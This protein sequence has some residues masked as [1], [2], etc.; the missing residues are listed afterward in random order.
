MDRDEAKHILSLCRPGNDE[1]RN[2][3][4]IAEA[5]ALL[6]T[7]AELNAWFENEQAAD[8]RIA[9]AFQTIEPPADLKASILA[10]MRA[11]A[12]QGDDES[13]K[14]VAFETPVETAKPSNRMPLWI[15]IAACFAFL[16]LSLIHI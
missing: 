14:V 3:S 10:G 4:V 16:F 7:D 15:G 6:E 13:D 9:D 5:L 8:A 11:H 1:D 2:D 12:Q